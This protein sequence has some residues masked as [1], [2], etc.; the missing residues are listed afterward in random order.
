MP[1]MLDTATTVGDYAL[2]V[3]KS[4]ESAALRTF[5][6]FNEGIQPFSDRWPD[7]SYGPD[8]KEVID[9]TF[10]FIGKVVDNLHGFM[11]EAVDAL[12]AKTAEKPAAP[13]V[14]RAEKAA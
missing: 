6:V 1:S 5:K 7:V 3:L 8:A 14:A 9:W 2:D 10:T 4:R 12:P 11:D 13:K